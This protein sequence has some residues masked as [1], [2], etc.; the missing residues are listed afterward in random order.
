M[1]YDN[2]DLSKHLSE[3]DYVSKSQI[4]NGSSSDT[5]VEGYLMLILNLATLLL[6]L[7]QQVQPGSTH[8]KKSTTR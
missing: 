7:W 8:Q 5:D 1:H 3:D 2:V 6:P 4:S